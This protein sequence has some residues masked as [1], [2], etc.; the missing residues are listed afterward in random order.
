MS[1]VMQGVTNN[2]DIDLFVDLIREAARLL[3]TKDSKSPSLRVIADHIR[4]CS[5]S[6][7]T[8][9]SVE[10]GPRLRAAPYRASCDASRLQVR[11]EPAFFSELVP[12]LA[13]V[14]GVA[15][16]ELGAKQVFVRDVASQRGRAVRA[17][18]RERHG[19]S[20]RGDRQG[21]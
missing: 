21:R 13:K 16:P 14:M 11:C 19:D 1:A 9:W 6:S 5:F 20:G 17:H 15:Y 2:Y 10:R 4:A 7:S 3:G 18:A 8:L 12:T